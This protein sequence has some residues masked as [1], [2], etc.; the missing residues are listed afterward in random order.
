LQ[1]NKTKNGVSDTTTRTKPSKNNWQSVRRDKQAQITDSKL[2][3]YEVSS[4][5]Q[6]L[7]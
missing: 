1:Q 4:L 7:T 2:Y 3:G 6:T 5:K